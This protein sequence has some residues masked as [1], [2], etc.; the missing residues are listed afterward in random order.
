LFGNHIG[1]AGAKYLAEELKH[2]TVFEKVY[3]NVLNSFTSLPDSDYIK[4]WWKFN[5]RT[6][7]TISF[8]AIT[9]EHSEFCFCQVYFF[10]EFPLKRLAI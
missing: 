3:F 8:P 6:R 5:W 10:N 2:N 1:D 9:K 7:N 4:H